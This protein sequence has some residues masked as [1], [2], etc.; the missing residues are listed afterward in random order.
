MDKQRFQN[1]DQLVGEDDEDT[2]LLRTMARE[3]RSY[4]SDFAWC[5]PI[6]RGL[7]AWGVGGVAALFLFEFAAK[8]AGTDD[9]LWVVTG[10]L[11]SAY[12]VVEPDDSPK[13]A[14]ERYCEVMD[15]W[16]QA[17]LGAEDLANVFPVAAEPSIQNAGLL[18]SRTDFLRR[19]II[20]NIDAGDD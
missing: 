14:M 12:I 7:L 3:A 15:Q 2:E 9:E 4:I 8:I 19:E 1:I 5:P 13:E 10:D 18:R 17:A 16:I 6:R 20:P 11:P